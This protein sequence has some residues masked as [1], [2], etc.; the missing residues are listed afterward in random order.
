MVVT[1]RIRV[2][3]VTFLTL[4]DAVTGMIGILLVVLV[5]ARPPEE[6]VYRLQ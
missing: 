3:S 5:L 2:P 4:T 6:A 1:S